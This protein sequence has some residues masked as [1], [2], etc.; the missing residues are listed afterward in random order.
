[1]VQRES[2]RPLDIREGMEEKSKDRSE[3]KGTE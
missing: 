3:K 2:G 1:M